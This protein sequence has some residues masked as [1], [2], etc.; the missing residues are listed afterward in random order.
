MPFDRI[1]G[2]IRVINAGSVGMPFGEPG[3]DWVLL[4]PDVQLRHTTYDLAGAVNRIRAT[5]YPQ[6]EEFAAS[7][8]L[9]PPSEAAMLDAHSRVIQVMSR[10]SPWTGRRR[11]KGFVELRS[12]LR[13]A[14]K[15]R[16]YGR[17][18][19]MDHECLVRHA[20][21]LAPNPVLRCWDESEARVVRRVAD[22][23][24]EWTAR[25]TEVFGSGAN[26]RRSDS[27]ALELRQHRHR[28]QSRTHER[29]FIC[30]DGHG[31]EE[32]MAHNTGIA[33]SDQGHALPTRLS[34]L[35]DKV[36]F[37]RLRK[38][39]VEDGPDCRGIVGLFLTNDIRD[40]L[41]HSINQ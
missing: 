20:V 18:K 1:A 29:T 9:N 3:A 7:Y 25:P 5:S 6:A 32:D 35:V 14:S 34:Q 24:D 26:E 37:D 12:V 8:V 16:R 13:H 40:R 15:P 39:G 38:R 23:D 17:L 31:R 2:R 41:T 30:L 19:N 36:S 27:G 4:G 11:S 22:H 33:Q 21:P 28:R 10:V